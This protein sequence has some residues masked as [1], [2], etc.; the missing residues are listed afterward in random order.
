VVFIVKG[1]KH[2]WDSRQTLSIAEKEVG[3]VEV[4]CGYG[5]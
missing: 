3:N 1:T 2:G 5:F 4:S